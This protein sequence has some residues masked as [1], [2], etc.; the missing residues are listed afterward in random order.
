[1]RQPRVHRYAVGVIWEGAGEAGTVDYAS[2]ARDFRVEVEGKPV[3]TGSAD[4]AFRGDARRH[5]P[6]ELLL[7][8]V[9]SCHMLFFLSLCARNGIAIAGYRDRAR[10]ALAT[11]PGGGGCFTEV[12]LCPRVTVP[13][14][15]ADVEAALLALHEK[16]GE[17]CFIARSCAFPI[18]HEPEVEVRPGDRRAAGGRR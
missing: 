13:D 2:Y 18:R 5:N 17:L 16:A 3:L 14:G 11:E 10:G 7:A 8:A 1:M 4:P 12:T 9:S 6:E 15:G